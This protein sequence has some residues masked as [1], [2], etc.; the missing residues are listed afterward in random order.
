MDILLD[1]Y[2]PIILD[3]KR[4]ISDT[5]YLAFRVFCA[6]ILPSPA[7]F[8]AARL[9]ASLRRGNPLASGQRP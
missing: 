8:P 3:I 6:Y 1:I 4:D 7:I 2:K 9:F 5:I